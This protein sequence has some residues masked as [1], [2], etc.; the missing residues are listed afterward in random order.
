[1]AVEAAGGD[2]DEDGECDA[3]FSGE[4]GT[5]PADEDEFY[6]DAWESR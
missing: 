1:M 6:A 5:G 3:A 2:D 4:E